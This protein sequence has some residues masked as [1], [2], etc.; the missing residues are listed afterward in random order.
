[1]SNMVKR[2]GKI[3]S[4]CLAFVKSVGARLVLRTLRERG[5]AN[6]VVRVERIDVSRERPS[7][8]DLTVLPHHCYLAN[9]LLVSNSNFSDAFQTLAVGLTRAMVAEG[10]GGMDDDAMMGLNFDDERPVAAAF[11]T[12]YGVF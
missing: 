5:I 4:G 2:L 12:D 11:E 6:C 7:V 1:M 8:F 9:G 10:G 3:V